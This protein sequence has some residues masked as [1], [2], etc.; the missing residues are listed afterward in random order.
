MTTEDDKRDWMHLRGR[1]IVSG[2]RSAS[3]M[4]R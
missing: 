2:N 1:S 4:R 3:D